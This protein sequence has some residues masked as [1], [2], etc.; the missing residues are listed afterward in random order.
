MDQA[1]KITDELLEET[2]KRI[3]KLYAEAYKDISKKWNAY[4]KSHAPKVE[5]ALIE[6]QEALESND[7][8]R[9]SKAREHYAHTVRNVTV[10]D[11]R[12]R[13]MR[14]E[15]VEKISHV[16]E[17]ALDYVNDSMA[18][19]YTVNYNAFGT[20]KVAGYSFAL[21][22]EN[23]VKE[24]A[25]SD[26]LLLPKKKVDI[27]KDEAWNKKNINSQMFQ[28]I[29]QGESM[30]KIAKRLRNVTNMNRVSSVRNARTMF[31][32][33]ENK[34]RQDSFEKASE[35]GVIMEREWIAAHDSHTRAWHLDLHGKRV[36]VDEPWENDYGKIMYPGDPTADPANVYNCR[37]A[38]RAHVKGFRWNNGC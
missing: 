18:K 15:V 23:A 33:A 6:L 1:R 13:A 25:M 34:G 30:P 7:R 20:Q 12:F 31:T 3:N 14:D 32:S 9:I 21:V 29:L 28:G 37:C 2:E 22:N 19:V 35:D 10:N 4:M 36:A 24:L 5:K 26:D 11:E 16:N 27:P 38:I 17:V 8:D